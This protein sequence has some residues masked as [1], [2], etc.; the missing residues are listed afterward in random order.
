MYLHCVYRKNNKDSK[1]IIITWV[2]NLIIATPDLE[3]IDVGT[4]LSQHMSRPLLNLTYVVTRLSQHSSRP[5]Q[6]LNY[7]E[8]R[9][10]QHSSRPL[11]GL[12]YVETRL[13]QQLSRP[14]NVHLNLSKF[15]SKYIKG[16]LDYGLI[17][18]KSKS[19]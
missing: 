15:I 14:T 5:L 19:K 1:I 16:T 11:Q 4:R 7:V 6:G 2:D 10:S 13:S 18:K 9:L 8:T 17:F 3:S 12:N